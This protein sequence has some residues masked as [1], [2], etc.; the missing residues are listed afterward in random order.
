MQGRMGKADRQDSHARNAGWP[1][2]SRYRCQGCCF[3]EALDPSFKTYQQQVLANAQALANKLVEKGLRLVSGGT[4]NHLLLVDLR[5]LDVTGKAAE[6]A[7]EKAAITVNKNTIPFDPQKPF[8][9]SGVRIGTPAVTSR[10]MKEE[11]MEEI[12]ELIVEVLKNIDDETVAAKVKT[13][14]DALCREFPIYPD[15]IKY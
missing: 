13:R 11:Q 14:I 8:V 4:D 6:K 9:A 15:I 1:S 3:K 2:L 5:P 12:G 7:L 10:G